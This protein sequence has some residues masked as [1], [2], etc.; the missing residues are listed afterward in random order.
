M[1]EKQL[2][3]ILKSY[4]EYVLSELQRWEDDGRIHRI[5]K[6]THLERESP[7]E[8]AEYSADVQVITRNE[9]N[10]R[11]SEAFL[12]YI[13]SSENAKEALNAIMEFPPKNPTMASWLWNFTIGILNSKI[14]VIK[15][16]PFSI[17]IDFASSLAGIPIARYLKAKIHGLEVKEELELRKGI[18]LRPAIP[19]DTDWEK[20]G[21]MRPFP[22]SNLWGPPDSILEIEMK[23]K[24]ALDVNHEFYRLLH[25][26]RL[27]RPR[28]IGFSHIIRFSGS[29]RDHGGS[30]S[31][32]LY[33]GGYV[34]VHP[35]YEIDNFDDFKRF[36]KSFLPHL[37]PDWND[38]NLDFT[39]ALNIAYNRYVD[40]LHN[41]N[42]RQRA[43]AFAVMGL[44]A[45]ILKKGPE[46]TYKFRSR[47]ARLF[48]YQEYEP[49]SVDRILKDAYSIRSDFVHGDVA[50]PKGGKKRTDEAKKHKE[51]LELSL[52]FLR[53]C[54]LIYIVNGKHLSKKQLMKYIDNAIIGSDTDGEEKLDKILKKLR[55]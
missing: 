29:P 13:H 46:L 52:E 54:I 12:K 44:E 8:V 6:P 17:A 43:I 48:S 36:L 9:W 22:Q 25:L 32:S 28:P 4:V 16:D 47:L 39:N 55:Y 18:I 37:S 51:C 15:F 24:Y 23:S 33:G 30:Y 40:A 19:E 41:Y 53:K 7:E 27:Y 34:N 31:T 50:S 10:Y 1:N 26:F 14:G 45:L 35:R 2:A 38:Y 49:R 21:Y 11:E 20:Q 3:E 5:S 42:R